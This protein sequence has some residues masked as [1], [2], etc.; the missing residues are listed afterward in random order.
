MSLRVNVFGLT[1]IVVVVTLVA[2]AT[3]NCDGGVTRVGSEKT[4]PVPEPGEPDSATLLQVVAVRPQLAAKLVIVV[5]TGTAVPPSISKIGWV[6]SAAV[7][8]AELDIRM[9]ELIAP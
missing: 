4:M 5:P 7:N 3:L 1:V 6:K 2:V 9:P 8:A